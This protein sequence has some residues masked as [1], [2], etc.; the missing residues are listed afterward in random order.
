[1]NIEIPSYEEILNRCLD[2]IPNTLDKRQGSIIYD[3]IAPIC[4]ELAQMYIEIKSAID[5]VFIDTAT[6]EYLDRKAN[7]LGL[8]RYSATKAKRKATFNKNVD[9]GTRFSIDNIN[10]VVTK[11]IE[12][13][14][15]ELTC[16][17][18]GSIGNEKYGTLTAI[19]YIDNLQV[20]NLGDVITPGKDEEKDDELRKRYIEYSSQPSFGGNVSDYKTKT[21][22]IEGVKG[23]KV[24]PVWNG[25]GTVKL[26]ITD[27]RNEVPSQELVNKVQEKIDPQPQ[28]K[29]IGIA[30]IGHKV[31]VEGVIYKN[32]NITTSVTLEEGITLSN[33]LNNINEVVDNYFSRLKENW[34]SEENIIVR[35]AQIETRILGISGVK[36]I[37][38]TKINNLTTNITLKSNEIPKKGTVVVNE[39]A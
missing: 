22:E 10:Y 17:Q 27:A 26:I 34:D 25:G 37:Q 36:D 12:G 15:F 7:D 35:I 1:M 9:I 29:G 18:Y 14:S 2:R 19:S 38:N 3:S 11:H 16:E 30:P 13:Y 33:I 4:A 8:K 32:I 39:T 24:I 5:L 31:T 23:V 20:A 28:Q 6:G 21:K